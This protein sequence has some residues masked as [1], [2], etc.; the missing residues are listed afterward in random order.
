MFLLFLIVVIAFGIYSMKPEERLKAL[1]AGVAAIHR[2]RDDAVKRMQEP[3]PHVVALRERTRWPLVTAALVLLHVLTFFRMVLADGALTDSATLLAWGG[4]FGPLTTNGEW[5]RL[6]AAT[7]IHT[8]FLQL[9]VNMAALAQ[10]GLVLERLV[11]HATFALVYITA[12]IVG[13]AL[14]L[15]ASSLS[16][17]TG[18]AAALMAVYGLLVASTGWSL[19][20]PTAVTI[21]L[22]ALRRLAP[23][24]VLFLLSTL[25]AGHFASKA[26]VAGFIIG[27][28][29]G[30]A[31]TKGIGERKPSLHLVGPAAAVALTVV[32]AVAF[33]LRGISDVRPEIARIVELEGRAAGVY[34]SAVKQFR[35]GAIK[36]DALAQIIDRSIMPELHAAQGRMKAFEGDNI[37]SEHRPLVDG[38]NEYL[39]LRDESWRQR[40]DALRNSNMKALRQA[41]RTE[42]ESLEAFSKL[43]PV[44]KTEQ[45]E[46]PPDKQ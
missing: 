23:I 34:E 28:V 18:P 33:P 46:K 7:F 37:P 8:G 9:V 40:A 16:T 14:D 35:L 30:L 44:E 27:L 41:D 22:S 4:N 43:K 2:L 29:T 13:S 17:G 3:E 21:P 31:L 20:Q 42:W 15:Y 39:R 5:W 32:I 12:A 11:G 24:A 36:A 6:I 25:A 38:A 19:V 26:P 45:P 10:V 1:R